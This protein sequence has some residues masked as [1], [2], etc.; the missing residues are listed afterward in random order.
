MAAICKKRKHNPDPEPEACDVKTV[1]DGKEKKPEPEVS[2]VKTVNGSKEKTFAEH[3][4]AIVAL[5]EKQKMAR[6][7]LHDARDA[8]EQAELE[9]CKGKD[10]LFVEWMKT[11]RK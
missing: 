8:L 7:A 11:T 9:V 10:Q 6:A 4:A 2:D 5:K 3:Q 1:S